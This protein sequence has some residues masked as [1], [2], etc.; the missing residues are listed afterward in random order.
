MK[1]YLLFLLF[2]VGGTMGVF[3]AELRMLEPSVP[4]R[5]E[6]GVARNPI[7]ARE[8][9]TSFLQVT[10]GSFSSLVR[11]ALEDFCFV[12]DIPE[13]ITIG[14][15]KDVLFEK[16]GIPVAAQQYFIAGRKLGDQEVL[17]VVLLETQKGLLILSLD[18]NKLPL[19]VYQQAMGEVTAIAG[20][21]RQGDAEV[22]IA[23]T[24]AL[25]E[26]SVLEMQ[27]LGAAD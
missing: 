26:L 19:E 14:R 5:F 23:I 6:L 18:N 7:N 16:N 22:V 12:G 3:S 27:R 20:A 21:Y 10:P 8:H 24:K 2:V 25:A 1:K 9:I 11:R 17:N 15:L 13:G 4:C